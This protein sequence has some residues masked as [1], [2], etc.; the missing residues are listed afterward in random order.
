MRKI[1]TQAQEVKTKEEITNWPVLHRHLTVIEVAEAELLDIL[2]AD[3]RIGPL[4]V[5]K[6]SDCIALVAP[7]K[8]NQVIRHLLKA[9]HTPKIISN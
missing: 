1:T 6:V 9:G 2:Q 5:A 7:G 8:V 4:I 3:R